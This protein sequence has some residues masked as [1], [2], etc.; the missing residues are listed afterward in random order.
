MTKIDP[1]TLSDVENT[2]GDASKEGQY[3]AIHLDME[4]EE[5][6]QW[7]RE[8]NARLGKLRE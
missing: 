8:M 4:E 5:Q 2:Y 3:I 7:C 1:S 6:K